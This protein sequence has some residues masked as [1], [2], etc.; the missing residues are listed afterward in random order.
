VDLHLRAKACQQA[1]L[2]DDGPNQG[3]EMKARHFTPCLNEA[4]FVFQTRLIQRT[5]IMNNLVEDAGDKSTR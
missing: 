4:T 2:T 1:L 5:L 3:T